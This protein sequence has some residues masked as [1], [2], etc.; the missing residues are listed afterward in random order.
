MLKFVSLYIQVFVILFSSGLLGFGIYYTVSTRDTFGIL[1]TISAAV[2]LR[3]IY[4]FAEP[5][6][7]LKIK[8]KKRIP[9]LHKG[10]SWVSDDFDE[11]LSDEFWLGSETN[12]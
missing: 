9:D 12:H 10:Q 6:R 3:V 2:M 11:P 8:K 5:K 7:K 4:V 1:M